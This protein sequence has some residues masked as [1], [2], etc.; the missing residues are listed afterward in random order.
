MFFWKRR[1]SFQTEDIYSKQM[2]SSSCKRYFC[3]AEEFFKKFFCHYILCCRRISE[4]FFVSVTKFLN[5]RAPSYPLLEIWD[6]GRIREQATG[7]VAMNSELITI[8]ALKTFK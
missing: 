4:D 6:F 3:A 2:N 8:L 7:A 5:D 1:Y